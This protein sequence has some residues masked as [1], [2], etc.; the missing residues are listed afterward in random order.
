M[1]K[2][3]SFTLNGKSVQLTVNDERSLL[4]VLR[5]DLSLTFRLGISD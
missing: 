3:I 5:T 4:W 1:E 2:S